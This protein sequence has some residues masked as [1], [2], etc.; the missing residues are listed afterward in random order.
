VLNLLRAGGEVN[1]PSEPFTALV[2]TSASRRRPRAG[3]RRRRPV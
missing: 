3:R 2:W 1:G